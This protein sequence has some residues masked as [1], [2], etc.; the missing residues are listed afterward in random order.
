M[1]TK[2]NAKML[3]ALLEKKLIKRGKKDRRILPL[4]HHQGR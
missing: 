4:P 3:G 2:G 1:G